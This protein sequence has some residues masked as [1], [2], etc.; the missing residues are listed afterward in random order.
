MDVLQYEDEDYA[1]WLRE[2]DGAVI[3]HCSC[4]QVW[5]EGQ[6]HHCLV[7]DLTTRSPWWF[8]NHDCEKGPRS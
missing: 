2:D 7:C 6:Q 4:G 5:I 3:T 8:D 1:E